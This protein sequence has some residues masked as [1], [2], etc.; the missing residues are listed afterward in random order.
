[1]VIKSVACSWLDKL[2]DRL[3]KID[4]VKKQYSF[5]EFDGNFVFFI[6]NVKK[7]LILQNFTVFWNMKNMPF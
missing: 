4:S 7:T 1:M 5:T 6:C 2:A 3:H